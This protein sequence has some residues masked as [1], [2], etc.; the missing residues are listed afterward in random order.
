[1]FFAMRAL[2][3]GK[4]KSSTSLTGELCSKRQKTAD[5]SDGMKS[6]HVLT[7]QQLMILAMKMGK[8]WK[9]IGIGC[10]KLS[11]EDIQQI[12]AKEED[13]NMY[14]CMMLRKW[15][16]SEQNNGTARSLYECL[17]GQASHEV[18]EILK[19]FLQQM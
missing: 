1:M 3:L 14:K 9:V 18:L 16:D 11:I 13:V 12:E 6:K 15:R 4:R 8:D 5:T 7:D 17:N 19:G 10:L 2:D